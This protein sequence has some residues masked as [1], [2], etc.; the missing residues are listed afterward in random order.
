MNGQT[1]ISTLM[2][3]CDKDKN[4]DT[5][6][7]AMAL[8]WLQ[9]VLGHI[10]SRQESFHWRWYEKTV[11]T[12]TVVDQFSYDMPTD[13]DTNKILGVYDDTNDIDYKYMSPDRM[14]KYAPD[15]SEISGTKTIWFSFFAQT[16]RLLP[17]PSDVRTIF[18]DYVRT[19]T[20]PDDG[21]TEL[22]IPDKY[23]YAVFAGMMAFAYKYDPDLGDANAQWQLFS[24]YVDTMVINNGSMPC[25]IGEPENKR[26]RF[27][28]RMGTDG[29]S[30]PLDDDNF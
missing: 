7:R 22:D 11:T 25:E 16:L 3:N 13:M 18:F 29:G 8:K 12:D 4:A 14:R 1:L 9:Y 27:E 17:V 21:T 10:D 6:Y 5:T 15:P 23:E 26:T 2:D 30:F 28:K 20:A 24:S 19:T